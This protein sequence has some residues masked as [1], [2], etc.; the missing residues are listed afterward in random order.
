M[1]IF[2]FTALRA[3]CVIAF[4]FSS[5]IHRF[6]R[7]ATRKS[8]NTQLPFILQLVLVLLR[9]LNIDQIHTIPIERTFSAGYIVGYT[10]H[11]VMIF[12]QPKCSTCA[13]CWTLVALDGTTNLSENSRACLGL[14]SV[15]LPLLID[16]LYSHHTITFSTDLN[17]NGDQQ[18]TREAFHSVKR[19]LRFIWGHIYLD[20]SMTEMIFLFLRMVLLFSHKFFSHW[21]IQERAGMVDIAHGIANESKDITNLL[22][23]TKKNLFYFLAARFLTPALGVFEEL[24]ILRRQHLVQVLA[25][26]KILRLDH[27][28]HDQHSTAEM[29]RIVMGASRIYRTVDTALFNFPRHL[30]SVTFSG[31][32]LIAIDPSIALIC[33]TQVLCSWLMN[34]SLQTRQ[35]QIRQE[36]KAAKAALSRLEEDFIYGWTAI[37]FHTK[38][39]PESAAYEAAFLRLRKAQIRLKLVRK[40]EQCCLMLL[41]L[42]EHVLVVR[43]LGNGIRNGRLTAGHWDKALSYT[44]VF[45]A[46][47]STVTTLFGNLRDA[48]K[49]AASLRRIL[50]RKCA[51]R[52][53]SEDFEP[54]GGHIKFVDVCFAYSEKVVLENC[55]VSFQ[56]GKI[57]AVVGPSGVG[58]S[59]IL[60]LILRAYDPQTGLVKI[61]GRDIK[62]FRLHS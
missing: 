47:V 2:W 26:R 39:T 14:G 24:F 25:H 50:E 20:G 41:Y 31:I 11:C 52:D 60:K 46:D 28:Y 34:N 58:K 61:D 59:T 19:E 36:L 43:V 29:S 5:L 27:S 48:L 3:L 10:L 15:L 8:L 62:I 32:S 12:R 37:L 57:T 53:G 38:E 44:N 7:Q 30:I 35:G 4:V 6:P 23:Q 40:F 55:N 42:I 49:Q 17:E 22:S 54:I 13:A 16:G 21:L 18:E 45:H 56:P 51:V 1:A 9:S 33:L